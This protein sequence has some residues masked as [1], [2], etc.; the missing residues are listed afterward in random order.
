MKATLVLILLCLLSTMALADATIY[1]PNGTAAV[2]RQLFGVHSWGLPGGT[3]PWPA[4]QL[5]SYRTWD[6]GAV[7]A[8]I[9][10][11][12]GNYNWSR[13]D[14]IVNVMSSR[15]VTVLFNFARTP[16]WA[17]SSPWKTC[18][19]GPGQCMPPYSMTDWG[20]WVRAVATRY[21]GRIRYYELWN[22][23]DAWN[24]WSGTTPQMV[25]MARVAYPI[26][27][28]V[29]PRAIVV[30]PSPQGINGYKWMDGFL[31]QGGGSYVDVIAF[32]GY[33]THP[34]GYTAAPETW[35]TIANNIRNTMNKY[36]V[37]KPVIDTE[38]SWGQN[39]QL[40]SA[41]GQSAFVARIYILH[42]LYGVNRAFWD[43]WDN[44]NYGTLY[45]NYLLPGGVSYTYLSK[46]LVGA[47]M[48]K[49]IQFSNGSWACHL[50]RPGGYQAWIL[51]N[52]YGNTTWH[53]ASSLNLRVERTLSGGK[54]AISPSAYLTIGTV[55]I[56]VESW[57][58]F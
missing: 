14:Q 57:S 2:D 48:D 44:G 42:W 32:H 16:Q 11:S 33:V 20:N 13:L 3:T 18:G 52:V 34:G 26:I 17:S 12:R 29:D 55:P 19:G 41:T 7:W 36:H 15:G 50:S 38:L 40:A 46:W 43:V 9:E 47:A 4:A 49:C 58:V 27:K 23:T 54:W 6:S 35:V 22:E 30:S 31:A 28:S 56:L 10:T 37:Y 45:H 1:S 39:W 5:G 21:K 25:Q 24:W 53:L 51:W 8:S